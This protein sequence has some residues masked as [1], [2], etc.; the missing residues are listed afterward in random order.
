MVE[1]L[2]RN[3]NVPG[4]NSTGILS[5]RFKR[6][7]LTLTYVTKMGYLPIPERCATEAMVNGPIIRRTPGFQ[8]R[9]GQDMFYVWYNLLICK[10]PH[11]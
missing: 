7:L 2:P 4:S 10:G 9:I 8:K 5:W 11:K 1:L 6:V 3:L